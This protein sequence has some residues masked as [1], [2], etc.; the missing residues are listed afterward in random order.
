L[1]LTNKDNVKIGLLL[2]LW[3]AVF[4]PVYP[5]MVRE[6]NGHSDNSHGF[7]VP[8][9]AGYFAWQRKEHIQNAPSGSSVWGGLVLGI[10]LII[11][12]LSLAGGLSFP[13]RFTLVMALFG[14]VW[15]CMGK[16]VIKVL[17]FPILF[18][19]F[20]IPVPYSL[21][22][23]VSVPLQLIA[24]KISA[25]VISAC[26]IPVYREGN[27]LFFVG[28]QL[29][30]AEACS[31]IRSIMSLSMLAVAFTTMTK[32]GWKGKTLLILSAIPIAMIANI[33]RISGTGVLANFFGDKVARGFLHEFSGLLVFAFG[34]LVL[35]GLS[36][37]LNRRHQQ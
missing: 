27:L 5:D 34:F 22:S 20:M 9:M 29:E 33:V 28:T 13:S 17:S 15:C 21:L 4:W 18:L 6:W 16:E 3:F 8:L 24:T 11:Y 35:L 36:S 31:G 7:I 10:S 1:N 23:L 32:T 26:S 37:F 30:V 14:L 19:L 2:L 25:N 12:L